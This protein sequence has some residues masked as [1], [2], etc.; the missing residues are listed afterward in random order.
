MRDRTLLLS[1]FVACGIHALALALHFDFSRP[2]LANTAPTIEVALVAPSKPELLPVLAGA[3]SPAPAS[4]PKKAPGPAVRLQPANPAKSASKPEPK[5]V[6]P[7]E[8]TPAPMAEPTPSFEPQPANEPTDEVVVVE[9]SNPVAAVASVAS[10]EGSEG[11]TGGTS[12]YGLGGAGGGGVPGGGGSGGSGA[13]AGGST[14]AYAFNPKPAYP[15]AARRDGQEG[16]V[17]LLV[18]VVS[19][20]RVGKVKIE[21]S[22]GYKLLDDA[23]VEAVRKW[24]FTPARKGKT[25]V[26]AWARV[27]I[28]FSLTD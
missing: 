14:P 21:K 3:S 5:L 4:V 20:G 19:N 22:S 17:L 24:R 25:P 10:P 27:P 7:A 26:T 6:Q 13:G 18:E 15:P 2:S 16:K 11:A 9:Q 28:E 1:A 8:P 23:A 12:G